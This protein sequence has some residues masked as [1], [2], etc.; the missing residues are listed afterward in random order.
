MM[1]ESSV[2]GAWLS[3]DESR[4]LS[5]SDKS[6]RLWDVAT[7]RAL[8]P[9][10]MH[11]GSVNGALL[12]RGESRILSWSNDGSVRLWDVSWRGRN[13]L[14]IACNYSSPDHDLSSVSTRYGIEIAD[15]ICQP[16]KEIPGQ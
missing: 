14:E 3:R 1:H 9:A 11:E 15:P 16:G 5:W 8:G 4:I 12:S 10:L 6:V 2:N 7:G 13:L